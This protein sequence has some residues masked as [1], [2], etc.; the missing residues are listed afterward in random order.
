MNQ[1]K[2][3]KPLSVQRGNI[4]RETLELKYASLFKNLKFRLETLPP[5]QSIV[6]LQVD[7]E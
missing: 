1:P 6:K 4:G 2:L 7:F 3:M 5:S